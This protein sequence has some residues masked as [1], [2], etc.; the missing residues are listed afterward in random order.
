MG[1]QRT[2][3]PNNATLM[4]VVEK[5]EAEAAELRQAVFATQRALGDVITALSEARKM[6][7]GM[8]EAFNMEARNRKN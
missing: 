8:Q 7:S 1:T 4:H 2:E 6:L 3:Q 5:V